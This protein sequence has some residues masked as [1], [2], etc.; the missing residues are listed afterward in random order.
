[1]PPGHCQLLTKKIIMRMIEACLQL[2]E[3]LRSVNGRSLV[4]LLG[5]EFH[6]HFVTLPI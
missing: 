2:L 6:V 3:S 5:E 4:P 1:M